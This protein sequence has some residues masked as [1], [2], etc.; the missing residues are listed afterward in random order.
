MKFWRKISFLLFFCC[1]LFPLSVF[2]ASDT[3]QKPEVRMTS[4]GKITW[5]TIDTKATTG[6]TWRTE[7]YTVKSYKVLTNK[8]VGTKEYGN[9]VYKKPYGK[10]YNKEEYAHLE[11]IKNGKY[12]YTWTIPKTVVDTQIKNAGVSAST[13]KTEGGYLYLNGFFR[14][15][16]NGKAYSRYLYDLDGIKS[17]EA[18]ATLMTSRIDL[19]FQ[20][21]MKLNQFLSESIIKNC[22]MGNLQR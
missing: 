22:M 5:K 4:D 15:Y 6:I 19:I 11:T 21:N 18:W 13:L 10:F 14:T 16:H 1:F 2:G 20:S 9:P 8:L 7:G 17:A 12:Y 3:N